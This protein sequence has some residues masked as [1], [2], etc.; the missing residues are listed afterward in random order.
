M[1]V[2]VEQAAVGGNQRDF[3][4]GGTGVDAQPGGAGVGVY[5]HLGGVHGVVTGQEGVVLL[6]AV[7]E[8][9]HGVHQAHAVHALLQPVQHLVK[10]ALAVVGG[11]QGRAHGG[12]AVAVLGED[13]VRLVQLQS[14]YKAL[15]QAHEEVEGAAQED[16]L[17]LQLPA[18]SQAGHRLVH[19]RLED[20]GGHVLFPPT[21]VQD[22]LNVA[23]GEHAAAGGDGVDLLVLQ[24]QFIQLVDGDVHQGGH[25]V[26]EGAG[27]AGAGA[28]HSFL[29]RSAEEDDLGILAAQLD[30]S[31]GVGDICIHRSGGGVDLLDK[32]DARGVGHAQAGRAGDDQL[33]LLALEHLLDGV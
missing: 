29:Q 23:L 27:A 7:K 21:L 13:G 32:V 12:K 10:G 28:V 9:G 22:G 6:L 15:P 4:G 20:G 11:A 26:D 14:L 24:R 17:A 16:D 31:V 30:D 19:H 8:G 18:L 33:Y 3:G 1:V 25:L 5:V 2:G